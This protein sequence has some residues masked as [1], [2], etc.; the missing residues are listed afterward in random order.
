VPVFYV[1]FGPGL[2]G[3]VG[4]LA[5]PLLAVDLGFSS[6]GTLLSAVAAGTRRNEVLLPILLF[7]L[8]LPL[9]V[10]GV[11]AT[12]AALAGAPWADVADLCGP[13]AAFAVIYATAGYLLFPHVMREG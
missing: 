11:K 2:R 10:L 4:L 13:L 6:A 3:G 8:T 7:P 1:L 5:A 9:A 12:A